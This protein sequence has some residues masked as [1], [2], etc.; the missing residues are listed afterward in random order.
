MALWLF[1]R[2]LD[3]F[4]KGQCSH[5]SHLFDQLVLRRSAF[6]QLALSSVEVGGMIHSHHSLLPKA[7]V[8]KHVDLTHIVCE[9]EA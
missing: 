2:L 9:L 1:H 5:M 4:F 7:K 8:L 6:V 3:G